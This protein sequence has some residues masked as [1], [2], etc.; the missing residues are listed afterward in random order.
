VTE[1]GKWLA[2][3]GRGALDGMIAKPMD[4]SYRPGERAMLKV[5]CLRTADCVVGGFRYASESRDIGSLLLGL[6]NDEGNLDHVGFAS[7]IAQRDQ[8][9]L[10][11]KLDPLRRTWVHGRRAGRPSRWSTENCKRVRVMALA[12]AVSFVSESS[13]SSEMPSRS[14]AFAC[15]I[16][17]ALSSACTVACGT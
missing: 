11:R 12:G 6:Y 17:M 3:A 1:A 4:E 14:R 2:R 15:S 13:S 7:A 10:K 5:K 16:P 9:A 8:C